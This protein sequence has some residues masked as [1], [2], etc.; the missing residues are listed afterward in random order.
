MSII[1]LLQFYPWFYY[2]TVLVLGLCIGSFLNVVIYRLP[3]MLEASWRAQCNEFIDTASQKL[4]VQNVSL[5]LPRSFCPGCGHSLRAWHN[6]PI[7]SYCL[8]RGKCGR[9]STHISLQ[10]PLV[11]LATGLLS[12]VVAAHFGVSWQTVA[13]LLL[14]WTLIPLI[15]IDLK[16]QL[17]PDSLTLPLLWLGLG[18]NLFHVFCSLE[19]AVIGAIAGYMSLWLFMHGYRLCTGKIG[20]GHGDFKLFAVFGAWLGWQALPLIIFAAALVG[21]VIGIIY[22]ILS[23]Q[24]RHTTI[25]FG[26]F[27][28]VAGWLALM[29]QAQLLPLFYGLF[30]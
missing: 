21:A 23:K 29:F 1:A 4:S 27:L 19:S 18:F 14:T 17:L 2:L 9:C 3:L 7:I 22:L 26:P 16:H 24:G 25:A 5:S 6:I 8:L 15:G 28:A 20:M 30:L 10:Y 11:E 12:L 13:A